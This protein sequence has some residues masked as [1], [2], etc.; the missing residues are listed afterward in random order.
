[1]VLFFKSKGAHKLVR[2]RWAD[3]ALLASCAIFLMAYFSVVSIHTLNAPSVYAGAAFSLNKGMPTLGRLAVKDPL[4]FPLMLSG[5]GLALYRLILFKSKPPYFGLWVGSTFYLSSF[6]F[7]G[8]SSRYYDA[9][10]VLGF[11]LQI[12][13]EL[14]EKSLGS[15]FRVVCWMLVIANAISWLPEIAY[16]YDWTE[17]NNDLVDHTFEYTGGHPTGILIAQGT[18]WD[19]TMFVVYAEAVRGVKA[20]F[21][22]D[23]PV[24]PI[25]SSNWTTWTPCEPYDRQSDIDIAVTLGG[26]DGE[27]TGTLRVGSETWRYQGIWISFIPKALRRLL[28]SQYNIW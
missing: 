23:G 11:A 21:Y 4:L 26:V 13:A 22:Y 14:S 16:K 2:E 28:K 20:H 18:P 27:R 7:S 17:R 24:V 12:Q 10:P 19:T 8:L 15:F 3:I 6:A 9:L 5:L 25:M 1:M